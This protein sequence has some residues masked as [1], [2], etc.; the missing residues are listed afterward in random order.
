MILNIEQPT[1][2]PP[3]FAL[4]QLGFRPFFLGAALYSLVAILLWTLIYSSGWTPDWIQRWGSPFWWHGHEMIFGYGAAVVAGFLLT[5]SKNWTGVQTLRFTPLA[6]LFSCWL[7][8][9]ILPWI[10]VIPMVV[11]AVLD[12]LFLLLLSAAVTH[13]LYKA[14]QWDQIRIFSTK[15][16][17]LFVAN[18]FFYLGLFGIFEGGQRL[19]LYGGI[20]L[21]LALVLTMGRRVIPFFIEKGVDGTIQLTQSRLLDLSSLWLFLF[22]VAAD[23]F[24]PQYPLAAG[25]L[26]AALMGVHLIRF[27]NWYTPQIWGKPLL[28]ILM[29]GYGWMILGF[30]FKSLSTLGL[31]SPFIALH[32]FTYGAIGLITLGMM[33][34]VSLGHTGHNIFNPPAGLNLIFLLITAGSVVR[35]LLPLL[36]PSATM[37]LMLVSQ[38]LWAAAFILFLHNHTLLLIRPR[39]DGR[40]G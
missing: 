19:G 33:A 16:S 32:A 35:V 17:L 9:R 4:F 21:I 20:Y 15:M 8:A 6:L 24:A 28:W 7:L 5:A 37:S 40:P 27:Y 22:F 11:P 31:L 2:T 34:R 25:L 1:D 18:L 23:L 29:V 38:L 3:S 36:L 39:V 13:P 26:A 10:G 12:L 14:R 30:L